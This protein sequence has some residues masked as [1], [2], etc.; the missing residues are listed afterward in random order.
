MKEPTADEMDE[1]KRRFA[2]I[3]PNRDGRIDIDEFHELLIDLDG[4]VSR[5]ECELDFQ[6]VDGDE[7]GYI[8]FEE[9]AAWW[10]G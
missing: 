6:A 2:L 5:E 4:D 1:L 8:T 7:D 9:F 3:D 10:L